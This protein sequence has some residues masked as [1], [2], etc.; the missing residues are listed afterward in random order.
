MTV[1]RLTWTDGGGSHIID[2]ERALAVFMTIKRVRRQIIK[3][4]G[5]RRFTI[6]NVG[7]RYWSF[8]ITLQNSPE[9]I[10]AALLLKNIDPAMTSAINFYYKYGW[11]SSAYKPV[12]LIPKI[13][14]GYIAGAGDPANSIKLTFIE[15]S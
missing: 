9:A 7:P 14:I 4:H 1:W 12:R 8:E 5:D 3:K 13:Q 2:I 15:T 11:D 6:Y 10:E